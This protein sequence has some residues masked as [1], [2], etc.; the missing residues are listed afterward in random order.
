VRAYIYGANILHPSKKIVTRKL[1]QTMLF[2]TIAKLRRENGLQQQDFERYRAFCVR[3]THKLR[4]SL[5]FKGGSARSFNPK[6]CNDWQ[7]LLDKNNL[8][9]KKDGVVM[10]I[11]SF[12]RYWAAAMSARSSVEVQSRRKHVMVAKLKK[13]IK[14]LEFAETVGDTG[15]LDS[16]FVSE[17]RAYHAWLRGVLLTAQQNW[18]ASLEAITNAEKLFHELALTASAPSAVQSFI[19]DDIVPAKR[20]ASYRLGVKL[21]SPVAEVGRPAA[22]TLAKLT[23]DDLV[24]AH[25]P[26]TLDPDLAYLFLELRKFNWASVSSS[27]VDVQLTRLYSISEHVAS[28]LRNVSDVSHLWLNSTFLR[29]STRILIL[30]IN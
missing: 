24:W 25:Q 3:K 10:L 27:T 8:M 21:T 6:S 5:K 12:E 23:T 9:G 28:R 13:A 11:L 14:Q 16:S 22:E 26:L 4:R 19:D 2:A 18:S 29:V 7:S 1:L 17:L 20:Y 15:C 30:C